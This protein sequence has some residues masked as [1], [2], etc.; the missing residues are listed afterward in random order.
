MQLESRQATYDYFEKVILGTHLERIPDP[1]LRVSFL[2]S[3][4]EQSAADDPPFRQDYWR[5]DSA[6][7]ARSPDCWRGAPGGSTSQ[8]SSRP[9]ER[10]RILADFGRHAGTVALAGNRSVGF[11]Q[12]FALA[13]DR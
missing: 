3:M 8:C 6:R 11:H 4:T 12:H 13:A 5:L 9:S 2:E 1:A 7:G 10:R